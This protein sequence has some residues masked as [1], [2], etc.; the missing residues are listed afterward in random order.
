MSEQQPFPLGTIEP[1]S[2]KRITLEFSKNDD[3]VLDVT[4]DSDGL[5]ED[6]ELIAVWLTDITNRFIQGVS[7]K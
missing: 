5:N 2:K 4:I 7:Q 3:G 6:P 1:N